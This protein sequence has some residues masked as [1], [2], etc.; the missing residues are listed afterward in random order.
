MRYHRLIMFAIP[1]AFALPAAADWPTGARVN[2][3]AECMEN[4]QAELDAPVAKVFCEC[5]A[6][7]VSKAFSEEELKAMGSGIDPALEERLIQTTR[8]CANQIEN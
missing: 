5:A 6:D 2:F 7:E 3:V 8:S 1:L 4:S